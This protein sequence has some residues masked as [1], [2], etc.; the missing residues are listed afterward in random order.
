MYSEAVQL[1]LTYGQGQCHS[2]VDEVDCQETICCRGRI[3]ENLERPLSFGLPGL[4]GEIMVPDL[5]N[6]VFASFL[7][8]MLFPSRTSSVIVWQIVTLS[9]EAL[10]AFTE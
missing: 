2:V 1:C 10:E 5:C 8:E 3:S 9:Y 6:F 4:F 7:S